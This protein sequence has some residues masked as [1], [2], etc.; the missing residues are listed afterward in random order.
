MI[1]KEIVFLKI[2]FVVLSMNNNHQIGAS[3]LRQG[4]LSFPL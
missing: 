1:D 4:E 3:C 2:I